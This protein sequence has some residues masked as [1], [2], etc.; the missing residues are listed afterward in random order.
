MEAVYDQENNQVTDRI[1]YKYNIWSIVSYLR[2]ADFKNFKSYWE[3]SGSI[4]F[5]Q[6]LF[7]LT[8]IKEKIEQ[9]VDDKDGKSGTI[10]FNRESQ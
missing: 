10:V 2:D 9:L 8:N 3:E 4:D 5:L 6:D 1:D 7:K